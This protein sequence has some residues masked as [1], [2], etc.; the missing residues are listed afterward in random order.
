MG[1]I[2]TFAKSLPRRTCSPAMQQSLRR[3]YVARQVA[4]GRGRHEPE[5]AFL[6]R[7]VRSGDVALE[8]ARWQRVLPPIGKRLLGATTASRFCLTSARRGLISWINDMW[9]SNFGK[10]WLPVALAFVL[11]PLT[12]AKILRVG[13]GKQYKTP[14]QAMPQ[15][16]TGDTV[17]ID[18]AGK[19]S[20]DVCTW[21]ANR[22]TL[23]GI[24]QTRAHIEAAGKSAQE[25]GI[26]V[27]AGTDTTI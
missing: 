8:L 1:R 12:D 7:L 9:R 5:L 19:Y 10:V 3:I 13:P 22:L 15:A 20:G 25:K 2:T 24:G 26:W 17:E 14:C 23:R 21:T 6:K 16:A 27:I 4:M 11:A 18:S